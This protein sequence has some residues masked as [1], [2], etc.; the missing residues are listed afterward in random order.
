[1]LLLI[2][3]SAFEPSLIWDSQD[4]QKS[5]KLNLRNMLAWSPEDEAILSSTNLVILLWG[6]QVFLEIAKKKKNQKLFCIHGH[7]VSSDTHLRP[8]FMMPPRCWWIWEEVIY[9]HWP[10]SQEQP[11]TSSLEQS[12]YG[13]SAIQRSMQTRVE[14]FKLMCTSTIEDFHSMVRKTK[15]TSGGR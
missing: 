13:S 9:T 5:T 1:M 7:S 4:L 10:L 11:Y 6:K 8:G 3:P 15:K 2:L 12:S 14:S